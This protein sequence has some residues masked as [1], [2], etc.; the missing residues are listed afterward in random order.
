MFLLRVR[1]GAPAHEREQVARPHQIV[2]ELVHQ[3]VLHLHLQRQAEAAP[4]KE[5]EHIAQAA[6]IQIRVFLAAVGRADEG[7]AAHVVCVVGLHAVAVVHFA[8]QVAVVET[9]LAQA[10]HRVVAVVVRTAQRAELVVAHPDAVDQHLV[11][12]RVHNVPHRALADGE[13]CAILIGEVAAVEDL[14]RAAIH[15][16]DAGGQELHILCVYPVGIR[17]VFLAVERKDH[18]L[19][20]LRH[21]PA[22]LV[23]VILVYKTLIVGIAVVEVGIIA[24]AQAAVVRGQSVRIAVAVHGVHVSAHAGEE[25]VLAVAA[26]VTGIAATFADGQHFAHRVQHDGV[27]VVLG[28]H[29]R[30][31]G[32]SV[33]Q[34]VVG[35]E[36]AGI[37]ILVYQA[38]KH[39]NLR[40][41]LL[42]GGFATVG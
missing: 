26:D 9:H 11:L 19:H 28:L 38:L 6:Y 31:Q 36:A 1:G 13:G 10:E 34:L 30:G 7:T 32:S 39:R 15:H 24:V 14:S 37:G 29:V 22:V 25:A 23:A 5:A 21:L 20:R 16:I 35:V 3:V 12:G 41:T 40:R 42:H 2:L 4:I 8:R 17:V 18:P 27:V 33:G